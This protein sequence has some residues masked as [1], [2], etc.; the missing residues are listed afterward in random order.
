MTDYRQCSSENERLGCMHAVRD[1]KRKIIVTDLT[2]Q[3]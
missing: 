2:I 1:E 3:L